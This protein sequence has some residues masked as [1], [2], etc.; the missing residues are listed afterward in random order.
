MKGQASLMQ[1][2]AQ[3]AG[4]RELDAWPREL[5]CD[6]VAAHSS[7]AAADALS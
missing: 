5:C 4:P 3:D 2:R 7:A 6:T 1:G